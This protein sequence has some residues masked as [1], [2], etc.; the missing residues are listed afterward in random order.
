VAKFLAFRD[1]LETKEKALSRIAEYRSSD[2]PGQWGSL[3]ELPCSL[4]W[5]MSPFMA[6][7]CFPEGA[8]GPLVLAPETAEKVH[9]IPRSVGN[10]Q[11]VFLHVLPEHI[12]PAWTQRFYEA[13]PEGADLSNVVFRFCIGG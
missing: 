12:V 1:C 3:R 6:P 2:H 11:D 10:L 4:D 13:I 8:D 7:D 5:L 9:G